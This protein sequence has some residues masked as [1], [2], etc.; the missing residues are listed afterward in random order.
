MS[1]SALLVRSIQALASMRN[2]GK[3]RSTYSASMLNLTSK[4]RW[5]YNLD[6][7]M[8]ITRLKTLHSISKFC[9]SAWWL[10][11]RYDHGDNR[12]SFQACRCERP[13]QYLSMS[14]RLRRQG[15]IHNIRSSMVT[16][17]GRTTAQCQKVSGNSPAIAPTSARLHLQDRPTLSDCPQV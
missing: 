8:H 6:N 1:D 5:I 9:P 12:D 2:N 14:L 10:M 17:P 13:R 7:G 4:W 3:T 16:F 11:G 15:L